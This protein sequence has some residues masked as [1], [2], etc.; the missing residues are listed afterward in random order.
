MLAC[1]G[2]GVVT[3]VLLQSIGGA[4]AISGD[5]GVAGPPA[6]SSVPVSPRSV[7]VHLPRFTADEA[8]ALRDEAER[9]TPAAV[10]L[11]ERASER[12]WLLR[13]ELD[14]AAADISTPE[15]VRSDLHATRAALERLGL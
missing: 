13:G 3:A 10:A 11:D 6:P 1:A 8:A 4:A 12:W 2:L 7:A 15:P 14:A 5:A 9:L